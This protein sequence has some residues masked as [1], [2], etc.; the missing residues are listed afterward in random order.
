MVGAR[1]L[2]DGVA[3]L[4]HPQPD[5]PAAQLAQHRPA[6]ALPLRLGVG[7]QHHLGAAGGQQRA[8]GLVAG[9]P[10]HGLQQR[11]ERV[12]LPGGPVPFDDDHAVRPLQ[13]VAER[14]G[15]GERRCRCRRCPRAARRAGRG[16]AAA[17][18]R[19]G[20]APGPAP[21]PAPWRRVR[22][23]SAPGRPRGGRGR[24][25]RSRRA[26][27]P[28]GGRSPA[29][30]RRR[31]SAA[32]PAWPARAAAPGTPAVSFGYGSGGGD[33]AQACR[34]PCRS[35]T[36]TC[37]PVSSCTARAMPSRPSPETATAVSRAWMSMLRR[38]APT[39]PRSRS[40]STASVAAVACSWACSRRLAS[41][42][43]TCWASARSRNCSSPDGSRRA[44]HDEVPE[45]PGGA[46]QRERPR[47]PASP[48]T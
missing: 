33:P 42:P 45:V 8:R 7:E 23:P 26:C 46:V 40:L 29:A 27:R 18:S 37:S 10:A 9:G 41:A 22:A 43:P 20:C 4:P 32:P 3:A 1:E 13:V 48:A 31:G 34:L 30:G 35:S 24:R 47:P 44:A 14:G 5:P 11:V 28:A 21:S 19:P 12:L 6:Q 38:S 2:A 36:A 25:A 16:A 17:R 15:P 39:L